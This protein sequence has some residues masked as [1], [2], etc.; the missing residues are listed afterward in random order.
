MRLI[1]KGALDNASVEALADRVGVGTRH[2]CRLFDKYLGA[3]PGQI[4]KT[5]RVQRAKRLLDDTKLPMIE[6]ASR[7]GFRSLRRFN[8]VFAEVYKRAPTEIRRAQWNG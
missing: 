6:I 3:S 5:T 2:L 7:A 4:A 8:A 1:S